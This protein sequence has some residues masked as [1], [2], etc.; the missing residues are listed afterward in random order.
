MHEVSTHDT[1]GR[2]CMG[3]HQE[4]IVLLDCQMLE[5]LTVLVSG[6]LPAVLRLV[7]QLLWLM[8]SGCTAWVVASEGAVQIR[9]YSILNSVLV[10]HR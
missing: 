9:A 2:P 4:E 7:A 6:L 8:C 5:C 1:M 3:R 10:E